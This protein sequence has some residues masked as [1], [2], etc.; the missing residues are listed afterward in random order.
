MPIAAIQCLKRKNNPKGANN[1]NVS[2]SIFSVCSHYA[3]GDSDDR[4][5]FVGFQELSFMPPAQVVLTVNASFAIEKDGNNQSPLEILF[6]SKAQP[7]PAGARSSFVGDRQ[8]LYRVGS[9]Y[10]DMEFE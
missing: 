4:T 3:C 6:D 7:L 9:V 1:R 5:A 2:L 10:V 8:V